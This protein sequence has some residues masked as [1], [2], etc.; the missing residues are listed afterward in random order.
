[1]H[2]P[3]STEEDARTVV[4]QIPLH[5][6]MCTA[7]SHV[8]MAPGPWPYAEGPVRSLAPQADEGREASWACTGAPG[9]EDAHSEEEAG[10]RGPAQHRPSQRKGGVRTKP[11]TG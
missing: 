3:H 6:H 11:S 5:T 8:P 7:S 4:H 9:A 10:D 2:G 1:M